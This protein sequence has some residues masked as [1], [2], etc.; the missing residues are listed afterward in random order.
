MRV[1]RIEHGLV[2]STNERAFAA[3][4]AGS[5]R[6]GDVHVADGQTAGRGRFGRHWASARG[7]GLYLSLVL[8]PEHAPN[9]AA[10]T[11]GAGLAVL[12]A[13]RSLG[14]RRARLKWPNDVVADVAGEAAKLA[15]ILVEA[16]GLDPASPHAVV[17]VGVNVLQR[18]FPP[19]LLAER[20]VTSLALLGL[21]ATLEQALDLVLAALAER[22]ESACADPER[23]AAEFARASE[24]LGRRVRVEHGRAITRGRLARLALGGLELDTEEGAPARI[25]LEHAQAVEALD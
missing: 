7:E 16:R 20:A 24:L 22:M 23:T 2:D 11:M 5:A 14:A 1:R 15:G 12:D 13:L 6:H 19:E 17:G 4:A 10:L 18:A 9:P 25:A 8:R 3:L 21:D